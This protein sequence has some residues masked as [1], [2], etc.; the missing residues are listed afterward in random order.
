MKKKKKKERGWGDISGEVSEEEKRGRKGFI[1]GRGN[2]I[3]EGKTEREEKE[4]EK[5]AKKGEETA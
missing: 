5:G 3:E 2:L 4:E 1:R